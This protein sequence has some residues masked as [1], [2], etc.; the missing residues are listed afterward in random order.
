MSKRNGGKWTEGRYNSFV[1]SAL[2]GAFRRWPPKFA[3]LKNASVGRRTNSGTGK[4]AMHYRCALCLGDYPMTG[5]EVDHTNPVVELSRGFVNWDTF[6]NRLYC[7]EP[8]LQVLCKPCHK[9]KSAKERLLR[10][11]GAK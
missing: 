7:E 8:Y 10:K 5:V 6:I 4:M 2:R 1:T 9:S 3:V 11:S